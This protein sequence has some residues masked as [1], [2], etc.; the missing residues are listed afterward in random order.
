M[1]EVFFSTSIF[2]LFVLGVEY[3]ARK[4]G[5]PPN[6][7]P[8]WSRI[9]FLS[10]ASKQNFF[11]SKKTMFF[12]GD[13]RVGWGVAENYISSLLKNSEYVTAYNL[14]L[15][16]S[17]TKNLLETIDRQNINFSDLSIVIN[18]SPASFYHFRSGSFKESGYI[19]PN[20]YLK[21]VF[22]QIISNYLYTFKTQI[23]KLYE[24]LSANAYK[25]NS[26]AWYSRT[27]HKEGMISADLK[28]PLN[29]K[30]NKSRFQLKY[31]QKIISR[32]SNGNT[33]KVRTNRNALKKV[34]EKLR[35]KGVMLMAIRLPV[36]KEMIKIENDFIEKSKDIH[37]ITSVLGLNY[38]DLN[39]LVSDCET[40]DESH[41]KPDCAKKAA[42]IL[43]NLYKNQQREKEATAKSI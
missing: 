28:Q 7:T 21:N 33:S 35:Q 25:K 13:S 3:S 40:Y 22:D 6:L 10:R 12:V 32:L 23:P 1:K 19:S 20:D 27:Y 5:L 30:F 17:N 29:K 34:I 24:T 18:Y 37:F 39:D 36:G 26:P 15:A 8:G 14:G 11:Q 2:I 42:N 9:E 16:A 38:Y 41:I 4:K 43:V 31:Y